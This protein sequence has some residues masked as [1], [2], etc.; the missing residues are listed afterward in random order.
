MT[1]NLW[2]AVMITDAFTI[3][4]EESVDI[5]LTEELKEE[6]SYQYPL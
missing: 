2:S 6:G 1:G 3:A 5:I 4:R